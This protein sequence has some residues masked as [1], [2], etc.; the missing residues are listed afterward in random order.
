MMISNGV[1][2]TIFHDDLDSGN[3]TESILW[4]TGAKLNF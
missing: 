4:Q 1:E 3:T 2:Y